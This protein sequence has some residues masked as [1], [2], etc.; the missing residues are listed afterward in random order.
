MAPHSPAA[1]R[2]ASQRAGPQ[3]CAFCHDALDGCAV[4]LHVSC[5]AEALGCGTIGCAHEARLAPVSRQKV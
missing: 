3:T 4:A 5:Q 1:V 2:A